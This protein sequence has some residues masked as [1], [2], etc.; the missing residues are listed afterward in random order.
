MYTKDAKGNS[1]FH[2]FSVYLKS[3]PPFLSKNSERSFFFSLCS[4]EHVLIL[5][6]R[7][8]LFIFR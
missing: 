6:Y 8:V 1:L 5:Y 3:V 7:D 2:T 4:H